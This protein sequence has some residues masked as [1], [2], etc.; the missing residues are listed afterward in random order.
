ME[1]AIARLS[2][3][4]A[5]AMGL[6]VVIL[7]LALG[8]LRDVIVVC[9]N[10]VVICIGGVWSLFATGENF[11]I[12][13]GVGFISILGVGMMNGLILVSAFNGDRAHGVP[14]DQCLR[15]VMDRYVRPLTMTPLTAIF[16][17]LPAALST[18]IGSESQKP[19][20]IVVVGGM[21]LTLIMLNVIPV[22]YSLYGK[23]QP[24]QSGAGFGH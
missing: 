16:G 12:S 23:R 11:N 5:L 6:I 3:V 14:L 18:K 15:D 9:A 7:Y 20:A 13:A 22:L 21:T 4:A 8:S 1:H 24:K 17:L 19:L 2:I 10:V